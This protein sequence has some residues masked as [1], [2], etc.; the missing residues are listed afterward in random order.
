VRILLPIA[1][2][3]AVVVFFLR[4][5]PTPHSSTPASL[6][7]RQQIQ[8][9]AN[10]NTRLD[11]TSAAAALEKLPPGDERT[12]AILRL[13]LQWAAHDPQSTLT[14]AAALED[15]L[16]R[17]T[18][19]NSACLEIAQSNPALAIQ[20]LEKLDPAADSHVLENLT[21]LWS[22]ADA[23]SAADWVLSHP[24]SED[25]NRL[26]AR[27]SH[28]IAENDPHRAAHLLLK[29]SSP[30]AAQTEATISILHRWAMQDFNSAK[31]WVD[32]FPESHLRARALAE[33]ASVQNSVHMTR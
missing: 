28:V 16:E 32:Q 13:A 31:S 23:S 11:P 1:A 4:P 15:H 19:I 9:P 5:S 26:L 24:A 33:L 29:N 10:E 27:V 21:H 25:R 20:T 3:I 18:A 7:T 12:G 17:Q 6:T 22:V 8:T 14:W 2:L 30:G